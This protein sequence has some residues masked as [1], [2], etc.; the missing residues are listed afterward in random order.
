MAIVGMPASYEFCVAST[1]PGTPAK[2]EGGSPFNKNWTPGH[3][4]MGTIAALGPGVDEFERVATRVEPGLHMMANT[5]EQRA[6]IVGEGR[7]AEQMGA[8]HADTASDRH[9][10]DKA[11]GNDGEFIAA[12][13]LNRG[14]HIARNP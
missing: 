7:R 6:P 3:E 8:V 4:Y 10:P 12:R 5:V 2:I 13:H 11:C 1:A 9:A 14:D